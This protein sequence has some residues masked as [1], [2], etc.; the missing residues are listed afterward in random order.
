MYEMFEA[1]Y[2]QLSDYS[3]DYLSDYLGDYSSGWE[4][5]DI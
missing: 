5:H 1:L 2:L 3:S 4:G